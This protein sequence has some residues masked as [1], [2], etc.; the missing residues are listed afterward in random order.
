M[1]I[2]VLVVLPAVG[3]TGIFQ[4]VPLGGDGFTAPFAAYAIEGFG[5]TGDA[6]AGHVS[7]GLE[8]DNRYVSLVS[9][10]TGGIVQ[11][12]ELAADM[13][14]SLEL[15]SETKLVTAVDPD[16][17]AQNVRWNWVPR[18][19]LMPGGGEVSSLEVRFLNVLNDLYRVS[20]MIYLYN[21]RVRELTPMPYLTLAPGST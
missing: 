9:W 17:A 5:V 7:L 14:M 10:A 3:A 4:Y 19:F 21:I 18:P 15:Q 1:S 20:T 2:D 13:T 11:G 16:V 12:T 6:S 8:M